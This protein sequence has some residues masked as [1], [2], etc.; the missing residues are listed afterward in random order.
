VDLDLNTI[1]KIRIEETSLDT[2]VFKK[3][4]PHPA[5]VLHIE[6]ALRCLNTP[7]Q[8]TPAQKA[9]LLLHQ[10]NGITEATSVCGRLEGDTRSPAYPPEAEKHPDEESF[11]ANNSDV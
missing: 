11:G 9:G 8:K 4:S 7:A 3:V 5:K 2:T 1:S 6:H 10:M